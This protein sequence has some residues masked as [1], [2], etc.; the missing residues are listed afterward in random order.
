MYKAMQ[1]NGIESPDMMGGKREPPRGSDICIGPERACTQRSRERMFQ[2]ERT[3]YAKALRLKQ[4]IECEREKK[5]EKFRK[6]VGKD[7]IPLCRTDP[8]PLPIW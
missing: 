4:P 7:L 3:T 5:K 8:T 1:D 2:P 6:A